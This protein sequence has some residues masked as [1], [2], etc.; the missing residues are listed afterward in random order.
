[1]MVEADVLASACGTQGHAVAA[2]DGVALS[3]KADVRVDVGTTS[4]A[5]ATGGCDQR[6]EWAPAQRLWDRLRQGARYG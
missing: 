6:A 4:T 2:L 1:M 3:L 5:T